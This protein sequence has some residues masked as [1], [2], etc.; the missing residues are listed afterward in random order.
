MSFL[1][2]ERRLRVRRRHVSRVAH[3]KGQHMAVKTITAREQLEEI[4][5]KRTGRPPKV[6]VLVDMGS[7]QLGEGEAWCKVSRLH[8]QARFQVSVSF[9]GGGGGTYTYGEI[10]GIQEVRRVD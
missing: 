3:R 8:P 1:P 10:R 5:L 4:F 6:R 2:L 7:Y 9:P